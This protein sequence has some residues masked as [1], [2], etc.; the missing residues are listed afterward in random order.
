LIPQGIGVEGT[1]LKH[2]ISLKQ[3]LTN[4]NSEKDGKVMT[5]NYFSLFIVIIIV[6]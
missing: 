1:V 6:H 3:D 5:A 2:D 4:S